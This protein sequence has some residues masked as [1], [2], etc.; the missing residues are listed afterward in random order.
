MAVLRFDR[1]IALDLRRIAKVG[2]SV[3]SSVYR[4][5]AYNRAPR[6][7]AAGLSGLQIV[8][9]FYC[10]GDGLQKTSWWIGLRGLKVLAPARLAKTKNNV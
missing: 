4:A 9:H 2:L 7:N 10:G 1:C 6:Q 3:Y 8:V 5:V